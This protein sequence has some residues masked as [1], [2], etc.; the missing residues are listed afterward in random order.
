LLFLSFGSSILS[1]QARLPLAIHA[2][3]IKG[4]ECILRQEYDH[5]DEMFRAISDSFPTHPAGPIYRAA[6][7]QARSL[8]YGT[9]VEQERFDLLIAEGRK[10][11][12][13]LLEDKESRLWGLFFDATA[14]GYVAVDRVER[15]DW[16]AGATKAMASA[17]TF[18]DILEQDSTFADARVGIGT[19]MYWKSRKTAF[20]QWIPFMSDDREEGIRF[21]VEGSNAGVYNKYA[22]MSALVSVLIDA[23]SYERA[24]HWATLALDS[25]PTNRVFL[26]GR[27]TAFHRWGKYALA[28][29]LVW[30]FHPLCS[31][32]SSSG[33]PRSRH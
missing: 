19:Y 33:D 9:L 3:V 7:L 21:L 30:K 27:A 1:A 32:P 28:V 26:W 25:F 16:F 5:A 4:L 10:R 29:P 22:S 23:G 15:G 17:G 8:D 20:L 14:D 2:P 18:E 6:V 24:A 13:N 11:T 31:S 12:E